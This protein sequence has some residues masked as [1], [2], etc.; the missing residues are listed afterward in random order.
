MMREEGTLLK[1]CLPLLGSLSHVCV[2]FYDAVLRSDT[3]R[4]AM[5]ARTEGAS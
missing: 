5:H 3:S 1:L 2:Q 4:N